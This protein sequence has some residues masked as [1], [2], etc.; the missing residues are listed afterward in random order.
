[1]W[2]FHRAE[3]TGPYVA[4]YSKLRNGMDEIRGA[5]ISELPTVIIPNVFAA[6]LG[7]H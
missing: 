6:Y 1:M 3:R 7:H 4:L 2:K 5:V